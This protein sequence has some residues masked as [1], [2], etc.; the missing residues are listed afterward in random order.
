MD[1]N[2]LSSDPGFQEAVRQVVPP[3]WASYTPFI[4]FLLMF[5]GRAFQS[6]KA[7]GGVVGIFKAIFLGVTKPP[8]QL[9]ILSLFLLTSCAQVQ[10]W[11][12]SP[13][14]QVVVHTSEEVLKAAAQAAEPVLLEQAILKAEARRRA[15][16]LQPATDLPSQLTRAAEVAVWTTAISSAQNR[17]LKLTG[18]RFTPGKN[19][20]L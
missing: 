2:L 20:V 3:A 17:Y 9:V 13:T 10:S 11:I 15:A 18:H 14:G 5:G 4:M 1:P 16:L 8:T 12:K 19:P 6:L 7:N